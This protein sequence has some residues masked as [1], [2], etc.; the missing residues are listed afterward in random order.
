MKSVS[1][2]QY[3][4]TIFSRGAMCLALSQ[5]K[6][7]DIAEAIMEKII[8]GVLAPGDRVPSVRETAMTMGVTPNTAAN[9]HAK[10]RDLGIIEPVHGSGSIVQPNASELCRSFII[11]K[12]INHELPVLRR[13][14]R[15]L[16]LS[17]EKVMKLLNRTTDHNNQQG[18][19]K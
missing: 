16:G 9:A 4:Y 17:E 6:F 15:L 19:K 18:E 10:L 7:I 8:E 1:L 14:M 11:K 5:S 12:F 2:Y 13:R 3:T